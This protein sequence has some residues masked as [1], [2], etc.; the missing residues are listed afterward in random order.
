M[1]RFQSFLTPLI[2]AFIVFQKA[3]GRWNDTYEHNLFLFKNYCIQSFP[4]AETLT[5]EIVDG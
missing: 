5:Q 3:S 4:G 2:E 1:S